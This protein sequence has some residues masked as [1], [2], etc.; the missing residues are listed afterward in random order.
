MIQKDKKLRMKKTLRKCIDE[1]VQR[2]AGEQEDDGSFMS[3][4]SSDPFDFLHAK[5]YKTTFVASLITSAL[6]SRKKDLRVKPL[7]AKSADFL[8]SEKSSF[9][10]WNYWHRLSKDSVE[11]PY[12]DDL[13]DTFLAL[14]ALTLSDP[15]F[16]T[17]EAFAGIV[18]NLT[19]SETKEGG[20][21]QTWLLS[22]NAPE[23][24]QDVDI[25]V[26]SNIAYFLSLHGIHVP[27]LTVFIEASIRSEN[28][29]SPYYP[30][31]FQPL[32]FVSRVCGVSFNQSIMRILESEIK[33]RERLELPLS[34]LETSL[35]LSICINMM[36]PKETIEKAAERLLEEYKRAG[37]RPSPFCIDPSHDEK[38]YYG[39]STALTCAFAVESLD[40]YELYQK[41][42]VKNDLKTKPESE[43][44]LKL[45][46]LVLSGAEDLLSGPAL[47]FQGHPAMLLRKISAIRTDITLLP[48]FFAKAL[49]CM[50]DINED[51]FA[52]LGIANLLGWIAYT[53]YDDI[54]DGDEGIGLLPVANCCLRELIVLYSKLLPEP[55]KPLWS[56]VINATDKAM[57]WEIEHC[58]NKEELPD[59]GDLG[60]L[61]EKSLGHALGPVAILAFKG[62]S[63]DS[64]E[65]ENTISFFRHYLIARQMHDDAHDWQRDLE[66]GILNPVNTLIL[67]A[68]KEFQGLSKQEI[69]WKKTI[70]RVKKEIDT[71]IELAREHLR[72]LPMHDPSAFTGMLESLGKSAENAARESGKV[73]KFL[74]AYRP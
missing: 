46:D 32:Y 50:P 25:A 55:F 9:W 43:A 44:D 6:T 54:I 20:P 66:K 11:M 62:Y 68:E 3:V 36:A 26:N 24:W 34:L 35:V 39:G 10:S 48:L 64:E 40:S 56:K 67:G 28:I 57:I 69:F 63:P 2:I 19:A 29:H 41:N 51:D 37:F 73:E 71:H 38:T 1:A 49:G 21:Y 5:S 18:S 45:H 70:H 30:S 53:I 74:A 13:D 8:T 59:F 27:N 22:K 65:V 60:V 4:S 17:E 47:S 58:R 61:A 31:L 23:I 15:K 14:I 16:I 42:S 72:L 7:L 12:P 33:K 52:R